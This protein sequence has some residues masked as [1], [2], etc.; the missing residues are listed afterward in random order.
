MK[1][2]SKVNSRYMSSVSRNT[3]MK[4]VT[5]EA[6]LQHSGTI[7]GASWRCCLLQTEQ[8]LQR[9]IIFGWWWWWW[10]WTYAVTAST[11]IVFIHT[12]LCSDFVVFC[13]LLLVPFPIPWL[14]WLIPSPPKL[15]S[16]LLSCH[17][18]P[19]TLSFLPFFSKISSSPTMVSLV[20]KTHTLKSGFFMQEKTCSICLVYLA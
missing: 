13:L 14:L 7:C 12:S 19:I 5:A 17:V 18:Y 15:S 16:F 1:W 10:W 11:V 4:V 3:V 20:P 8:I 2:I 9:E 6:R